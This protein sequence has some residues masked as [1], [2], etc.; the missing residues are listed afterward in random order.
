MLLA[1]AN[2]HVKI[3]KSL[4]QPETSINTAVIATADLAHFINV[5]C[6]I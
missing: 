5:A 1:I 2:E 4:H 6:K 3:M